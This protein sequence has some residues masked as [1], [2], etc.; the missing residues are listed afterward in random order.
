MTQIAEHN[1]YKPQPL[2]S[3]L[4]VDLESK[5]LKFTHFIMSML[6]AMIIF[7]AHSFLFP[8]PTDI[9]IRESSVQVSNTTS[10]SEARTLVI[11]SLVGVKDPMEYE[12]KYTLSYDDLPTSMTYYI[13]STS[14]RSFQPGNNLLLEEL[15]LPSNLFPGKYTLQGEL[16]LKSSFR[17]ESFPVINTR[18]D[19]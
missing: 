2:T 4:E 16:H 6:T 3:L 9:L 19:L 8:K 7:V 13:S 14:I 1:T 15:K 10:S 11:G 18:V 12:M 5:V 17:K